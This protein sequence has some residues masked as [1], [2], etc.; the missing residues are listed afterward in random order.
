MESERMESAGWW[1]VAGI[2]ESGGMESDG[3]EGDRVQGGGMESGG[4]VA[5]RMWTL[6]EPVHALTYFAAEARSAFEDAGLRGFWRGYFAGRAAPLGRVAAA[7]VTASF[8]NFAPSMVSRAV[9]A[10]WDLITPER[11]LQVRQNGAVTVLGR[12]LGELEDTVPAAADLLARAAAGLD[13]AGRVLTSANAALPVPADPLARLWHAATVLRE[14]RG[15]GHFAALL[16]ADIDGSEALALRSALDLPRSVLQPLRGWTDE[17][18]DAAAAR[19]VS[20]GLL[21]ADGDVTEAGVALRAS[22]E[23]TTDLVAA[24]PWR[25]QAFAAEVAAALAP[26]ARACA[27]ELPFPNPIG[28]PRPGLP[29]AAGSVS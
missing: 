26:I 3:I 12:V 6:F 4:A 19:L 8:Y 22:V 27:A 29:A 7:Q 15:E 14:H 13:S 21:T 18:W 16:A 5:R 2:V 17:E 24:R 9:P 23:Q 1:R 10:I 25:D 28:V 20:R 11:A